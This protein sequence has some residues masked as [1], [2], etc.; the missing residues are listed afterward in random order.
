VPAS[1]GKVPLEPLLNAKMQKSAKS[2]MRVTSKLR[3]G[4]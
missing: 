4:P 2:V 1:E 3:A